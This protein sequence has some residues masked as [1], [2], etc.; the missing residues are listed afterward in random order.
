MKTKRCVHVLDLVGLVDYVRA[1][2]M[3]RAYMEDV[4][5]GRMGG[6]VM[7]LEHPHVY[8]LGRRGKDTDVL[9][10]GA[11][12]ERLGV[13]VHH[14]DRGGEATYHGPGQLVAYPI[15]DL[16][17]WGGGPVKYVRALE[18]ALI[19]TLGDWGIAGRRESGLPGVWVGQEKIA[20]VGV[21]ISGG[22]TCH[23]ISLN[24]NSDLSF[25]GHIV[26]C[27]IA[28]LGVTSM[29]RITGASADMAAV[30]RA[31]VRHLGDV[32]GLEMKWPPSP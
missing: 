16:R 24:V 8:T 27:G 7:L 14:V 20:F 15:L 4:R 2:D 22:V 30:K 19:R 6:V 32:M 25:Y 23:G 12:L 11:A 13:Q 5:S 17:R 29:E 10:D 9:L 26:P 18:E 31:L 1:W 3:Q 21:R 28:G